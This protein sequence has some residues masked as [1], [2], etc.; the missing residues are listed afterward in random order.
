MGQFV[1]L[2]S[3]LPALSPLSDYASTFLRTKTPRTPQSPPAPPP[4]APLPP[5]PIPKGGLDYPLQSVPNSAP[6]YITTNPHGRSTSLQT[7]MPSLDPPYAAHTQDSIP[8]RSKITLRTHAS[9]PHLR[10]PLNVQPPPGLPSH[11]PSQQ[12]ASPYPRPLHIHHLLLP[13]P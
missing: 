3:T 9:T 6:Y 11:P 7:G 13:A 8:Q 2:A 1:Q 5:L 4:T 10:M 12:C